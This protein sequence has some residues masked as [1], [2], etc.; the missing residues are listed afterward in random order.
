MCYDN[1]SIKIIMMVYMLL[2]KEK[3]GFQVFFDTNKQ[4][5]S[6]FKD[7]KYLLGNKYRYSQV[8]SYVN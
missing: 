5:Y 8:S 6:V 7:G 2:V 3:H 1:L 4:E